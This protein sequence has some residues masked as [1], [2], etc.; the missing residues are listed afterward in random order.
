MRLRQIRW[1]IA[2]PLVFVVAGALFAA[3]AVASRGGDLR[4]GERTE[5]AD[6]IREQNRQVEGLA[7]Q[8]NELRNDVDQISMRVAAGD[9]RIA[10]L[11]E[12]AA[13]VASSAGLVP[14][15]G[16]ALEIV[17]ADAPRSDDGNMP[18]DANPDDLVVHQQD[19]QAVVNALWAGGA[20]AMKLMDQR[21]IST[22]A[23]RC[24]GNTL[25]LQGR[26]YSPP[27][28]V[29]AIGDISR[30]RAALDASGEVSLYREYVG[31]Y[32]LVY[33]VSELQN[34][35]I[36]AYEGGLDLRQARVPEQKGTG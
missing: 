30:M 18:R 14:M 15:R 25:I 10:G 36:P 6:V 22:S 13:D 23:V 24:V 21:V 31:A 4:G 17:L 20:E 34:T 27:Y 28:V 9:A 7:G 29:T 1:R 33:E 26:V 11:R 32:G 19:V 12:R 35:T 5:L 3:G 2:T 16:P 8:V